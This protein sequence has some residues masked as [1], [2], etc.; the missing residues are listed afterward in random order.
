MNEVIDYLLK[1]SDKLFKVPIMIGNK[2]HF[3]YYKELKGK[4]RD[5]ILHL[6]KVRVRVKGLDGSVEEIEQIDENKFKNYVIIFQALDKDGKRLFQ[7]SDEST[8]EKMSIEYK[9]YLCSFFYGKKLGE[10]IAEG[11]RLLKM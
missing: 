6:S 2:K 11:T 9:D 1:E 3:L 10:L 8:V 7:I 4:V 5:S